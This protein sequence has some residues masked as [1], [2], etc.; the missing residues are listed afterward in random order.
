MAYTIPPG[1]RKWEDK[2]ESFQFDENGD[3]RYGILTMKDVGILTAPFCFRNDEDITGAMWEN[4]QR[5]AP[6]LTMMTGVLGF[7][8]PG[9]ALD[10]SVQSRVNKS[11][12]A[13][14][15]VFDSVS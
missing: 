2:A 8:F 1:L 6:V 4:S 3:E 12:V 7:V 5:E 13:I 15:V 9:I 10:F 11:K 14:H